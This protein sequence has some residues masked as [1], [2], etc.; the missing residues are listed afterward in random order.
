MSWQIVQ[1]SEVRVI[2]SDCQNWA[3][4]LTLHNPLVC[5]ILFFFICS[6]VLKWP[7]GITSVR[8]LYISAS[9]LKL[10]PEE[11]AMALTVRWRFG[12]VCQGWSYGKREGLLLKIE[13]RIDTSALGWLLH[14]LWVPR[15]DSVITGYK[16]KMHFLVFSAV[17]YCSM[18]GFFQRKCIFNGSFGMAYLFLLLTWEEK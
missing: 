11:A 18:W 9:R 17:C 7:M 8:I 12:G 1:L 4:Y 5:L 13:R 6:P 2:L 14:C 3:A 10:F 15:S 16:T